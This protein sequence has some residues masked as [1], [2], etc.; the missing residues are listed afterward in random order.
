MTS[1][2]TE[3]EKICLSTNPRHPHPPH[4]FLDLRRLV[5]LGLLLDQLPL[6]VDGED[7]AQR[8]PHLLIGKSILCGDTATIVKTWTAS[9][10]EYK[11]AR[12]TQAALGLMELQTVWFGI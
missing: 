8:H 9:W 11:Q 7:P 5:P 4:W 6:G 12:P 1:A 2:H 3:K 10:A